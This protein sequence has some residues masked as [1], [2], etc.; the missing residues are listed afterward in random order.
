MR[1]LSFASERSTEVFQPLAN[2][3]ELLHSTKKALHRAQFC[4]FQM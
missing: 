4:F 2:E 3:A 1:Y